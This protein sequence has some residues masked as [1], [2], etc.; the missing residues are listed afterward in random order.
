MSC[1]NITH[2][3]HIALPFTGNGEEKSRGPIPSTKA[4][5]PQKHKLQIEN[6]DTFQQRPPAGNRD[7]PL[8]V[9]Q[10]F[11]PFHHPIHPISAAFSE[12]I[13]YTFIN[14]ISPGQERR[15][16][17]RP[18]GIERKK[19]LSVTNQ[20]RMSM[21]SPFS[22]SSSSVGLVRIW[23]TRWR[24]SRSSMWGTYLAHDGTTCAIQ[25]TGIPFYNVIWM[26]SVFPHPL[27]LL[28]WL[29]VRGIWER[30]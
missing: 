3:A 27:S 15:S 22:S 12:Q 19:M 25:S 23:K 9:N 7:M 11:T 1:C 18:G 28:L 5:K 26:S 17:T 30:H 16:A 8:K 20:P 2:I 10:F 13:D 21:H 6:C 14:S 4:S 24:N 29:N